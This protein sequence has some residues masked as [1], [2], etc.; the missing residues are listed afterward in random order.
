[1]TCLPV[2]QCVCPGF[3]INWVRV[4]EEKEM[5]GRVVSADHAMEPMSSLYGICCILVAL[6]G[7][8]GDW[9]EDR[10]IPGLRGVDIEFVFSRPKYSMSL[11]TYAP[12]EMEIVHAF[13][14]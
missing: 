14:M 11:L 1:M 3:C 12:C 13:L 2:S 10:V 8:D 6:R 9:D 7:M 4:D 5:S